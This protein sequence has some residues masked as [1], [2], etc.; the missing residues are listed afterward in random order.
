MHSELSVHDLTGAFISLSIFDNNL[1]CQLLYLPN[2]KH[3]MY[4]VLVFRDKITANKISANISACSEKKL[5]GRNLESGQDR[6]RGS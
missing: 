6:I 2:K 4:D 5:C 1:T 3:F